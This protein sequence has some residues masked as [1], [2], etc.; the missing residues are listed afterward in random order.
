MFFLGEAVFCQWCFCAKSH[1]LPKNVLKSLSKNRAASTF[2]EY[3]SDDADS[4]GYCADAE[5]CPAD[6]NKQDAGQCGCGVADTDNDSVGTANC[7]DSYPDCGADY[8]D[9]N[10]DCGGSA[11]LD[12]CDVCSDGFSGHVADSDIDCNG[13]CFVI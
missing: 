8:Y 6:P 11:T 4:D 2:C 12:S 1:T 7:N 13:G 3:A 9:C 10:G 5:E